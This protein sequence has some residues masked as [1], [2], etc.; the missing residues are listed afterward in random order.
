MSAG[1]VDRILVIRHSFSASGKSGVG[2]DYAYALN[3][4]VIPC[5]WEARSR[6]S[7]TLLFALVLAAER[8]C[9]ITWTS[10]I[11]AAMA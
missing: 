4:L 11:S 1:V 7:W 2:R 5:S 10:A 8:S 9:A 3:R 6:S